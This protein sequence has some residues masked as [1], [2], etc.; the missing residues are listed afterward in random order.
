MRGI[1]KLAAAVGAA[2]T[3]ALLAANGARAADALSWSFAASNVYFCN[4]NQCGN[5][6][7]Q[8]AGHSDSSGANFNA[9]ALTLTPHGNAG[10]AADPGPNGLLADLHAF[11]LA[12]GPAQ[13][14]GQAN[15]ALTFV[16][17]VQVYKWT[18]AAYD[19]DPE[20]FTASMDFN[21]TYAPA[22]P[23]GITA[24]FAIL[25]SSV[26]ASNS[27]A[28]PWFNFGTGAGGGINSA[29]QA[30]C[31]TPGAVAI[32]NQG[33]DRRTDTPGPHST[34]TTFTDAI[35]ATAC[36]GRLHLETGDEFV[37]WSKLFVDRSAPGILD[38]SHTF[39]VGLID[40]PSD[41]VQMLASNLELQPYSYS[42]TPEPAAWAMMILG[43][44]G[45]GAA[46]RR[47]RTAAILTT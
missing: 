21:A 5:Q 10:G 28:T 44:G 19:L 42:P 26:L 20:I 30:D 32:A 29:F 34:P 16:E 18:G 27:A 33:L 47:R 46:A 41:T 25:D 45:V 12:N 40:L 38:A 3:L 31:N 8:L 11:A 43:F 4:F 9:T 7:L 17:G 39:H 2:V 36:N 35:G 1:V 23:S 13:T 37:L 15:F 6:P 14:P 24:G 22:G